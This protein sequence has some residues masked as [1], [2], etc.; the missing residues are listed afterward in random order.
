MGFSKFKKMLSE[1][2][3]NEEDEYYYANYVTG[4]VQVT[5]DL[6]GAIIKQPITFA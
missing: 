4:S 5:P 1:D 2:I 3:P 6:E